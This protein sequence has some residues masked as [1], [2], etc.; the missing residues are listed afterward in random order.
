M[1]D[2]VKKEYLREYVDYPNLNSITNAQNLD[3]VY[4]IDLLWIK[5][6]TIHYIFEVESTTSM[7]S[8]LLRGSNVD[9]EVPKIM[10]FPQAR[11]RQFQRKMKSPLFQERF[12]HD[13]WQFVLIEELYRAW[14]DNKANTNIDEISN[15]ITDKVSK[16]K[17]DES[18]LK[19]DI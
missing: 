5:E 8:A 18:Q 19:I 17:K 14:D 10:L 7:T 2:L 1:Q 15:L 13:K 12:E 3:T 6:N 11:L 16:R 9:R 4:G